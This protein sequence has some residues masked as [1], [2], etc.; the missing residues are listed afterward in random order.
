MTPKSPASNLD[1]QK[2]KFRRKSVLLSQL[3]TRPGQSIPATASV[4]ASQGRPAVEALL[5]FQEPVVVP[6][7]DHY[8]IV[9]DPAPVSALLRLTPKAGTSAGRIIVRELLDPD[10]CLALFE[11]V[12]SLATPSSVGVKVGRR[13]RTRT[14]RPAFLVRERP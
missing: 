10:R 3:I 1:P 11:H 13:G 6:Q 4:I 14:F 7:G 5:K 12:A 2:L 9:T 8:L